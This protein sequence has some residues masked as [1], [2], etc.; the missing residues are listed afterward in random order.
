MEFFYLQDPTTFMISKQLIKTVIVSMR[1]LANPLT[2]CPLN[3]TKFFMQ[4]WIDLQDKASDLG[5]RLL[6]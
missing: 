3:S 5:V 1:T 2:S 4:I 6:N